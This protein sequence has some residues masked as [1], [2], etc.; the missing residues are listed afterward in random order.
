MAISTAQPHRVRSLMH[1][2]STE[3][4][5]RSAHAARVPGIAKLL[6][7]QGGRRA[8]FLVSP[9]VLVQDEPLLLP[10]PS[11]TF[12]KVAALDVDVV[13]VDCVLPPLFLKV[14]GVQS[15]WPHQRVCLERQPL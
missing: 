3:T 13:L 10:V 1:H 14:S 6:A 9:A 15:G 5:G 8:E 2:T 4:G 7:R 12:R 11:P